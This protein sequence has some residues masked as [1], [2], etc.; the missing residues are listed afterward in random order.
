M[1]KRVIL[2]AVL[3]E[4]KTPIFLAELDTQQSRLTLHISK[5]PNVVSLKTAAERASAKVGEPINVSV[6]AHRLHKLAHP[7]SVEHWVRQFATGEIV[8]DPTMVIS[9][10]RG[11][12]AAV[13]TCRVAL[14]NTIRGSYFDPTHRTLFVLDGGKTASATLSLAPRVRSTIE[15]AWD[16]A[17]TKIGPHARDR[18]WTSIQ[19][20]GELPHR[21]L[22]PVDAVSASLAHGIRRAIR[23]WSTPVALALALV[24]IAV[25]A[26]AHVG[27]VKLGQQSGGQIASENAND[28][29]GILTGLSVFAD[30]AVPQKLDLFAFAGL[31]EY[32][33]EKKF[34]AN[35]V[36]VAAVYRCPD[37]TI[38]A[39]KDRCP[40]E[41][42]EIVG[43]NSSGQ[44]FASGL[45]F[46]ATS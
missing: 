37:G 26:S 30:N 44:G 38:V 33:G 9:R 23:R 8:Y 20:V 11:L 7:R 28:E 29:Y 18:Y 14:G 42:G 27:S 1:D 36:R 4:I 25:P 6:R 5:G 17:M 31:H 16:Q 22:I 21:R 39:D 41:L 45:G 12:L 35:G 13:K 2:E 34:A 32:F 40:P 10:A 3:G 24:G 19:V 15:E 43:G 46:G